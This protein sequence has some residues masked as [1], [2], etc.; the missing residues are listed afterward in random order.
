MR[1]IGTA[2]HVDHGKSALIMALTGINPDRLQ[3]EQ[4]RQMTIDLGFAW[5][6]LSDGEEIGFIDVPGHRDFVDNMLAGVGGIDAALFVIA[7][8]E[9]VMPQT[10]EH[11]AIIDL[12][13]V[14]HAV[15][16]L[17]KVDLVEDPQWLELVEEDVKKLIQGTTLSNATIVPVSAITGEGLATLRDE[18]R[19]IVKSSEPR[20]DKNR[21]RLSIDRSFTIAGF[22]TVVTGTLIDGDLSVGQEVEIL[23]KGI[24]GRIRGLQTHKTKVGTAFPGSRTAINLTGVDVKNI[25]RG[26]VVTEPGLFSTTRLIDVQYRHLSEVDAPMKHNQQVKIFIGA[27]Q[28]MA[29]VRVLGVDRIQPGD[30]GWIQ[31]VLEDPIIA[32]RGD[33]Y[34]IRRPS[35]GATLGGGVV[36]DPY[37]RRKHKRKDQGVLT[38]LELI[39]LGTPGEILA[40][41]LLLH[42]PMKLHEAI[43]RAGLSKEDGELALEELRRKGEVEALGGVEVSTNSDT[44]ITHKNTK[45]SI[46]TN[47]LSRIRSFHDV[48]PLKFGMLKEELRSR[49]TIDAVVFSLIV[50]EL[51]ETGKVN[52]LGTKIATAGFQPTLSENQKRDV[53]QL[54][55][56]FDKSAYSPPSVKESVEEVGEDLFGYLEESGQ[57]IKVSKDVV[58]TKQVYEDMVGKIREELQN[59]GTITV[60]QVRDTFNNTRKYALALME[61]LDAIGVTIRQGDVRRLKK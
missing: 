57:L 50:N 20:L 52:E 27:A 42:D 3:E 53:E 6:T 46:F 12:L 16:V 61:Y 33:H 2:G 10:K 43:E 13:E 24:K 14:K 59:N 30:E 39:L 15:I 37:P 45:E 36:A 40:Q 18:I 8:D 49:S 21:P 56:R 26:D 17:T 28:K 31:L 19:N 54:M 9:G 23:P 44:Y 25:Q 32:A 4:E 5:M 38:R 11:L 55:R 60:A 58:F 1:V 51:A 35:P 48:N 7:A 41:T 34:I 22:G 47:V 29:R